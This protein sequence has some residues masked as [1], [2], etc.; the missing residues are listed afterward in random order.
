MAYI[1]NY[2]I[3]EYNIIYNNIIRLKINTSKILKYLHR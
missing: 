1:K 2:K 3:I